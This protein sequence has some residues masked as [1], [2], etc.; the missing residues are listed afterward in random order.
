MAAMQRIRTVSIAIVFSVLLI[1]IANAH[2][3]EAPTY[4]PAG[5]V[6]AEQLIGPPPPDGSEA[7]KEGM[8]VVLWLQRTRTPEQVAF[9]EKPVN[10]ERFAPILGK[11]LFKVNGRALKKLL[12][13]ATH[14]ARADYDRLKAVYDQKRPAEVSDKVKPVGTH[15]TA[16]AYPSGHTIRAILYARLLAAVFPQHETALLDLAKRIAYGRVIAGQH[17]PIDITAGLTLGHAYADVILKQPA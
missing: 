8:A 3:H 14:Q 1:P 12:H 10:A 15:H 4:V 2:H 9:V 16:T 5:S 7:F 11:D 13:D 17:Y 6:N